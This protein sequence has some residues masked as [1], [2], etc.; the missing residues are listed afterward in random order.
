M[1]KTQG[2]TPEDIPAIRE[3]YDKYFAQDFNFPDFLKGYFC[4]FKITDDSDKLVMAG[5]VRPIAETVLITDKEANVHT[6][7]EALLEALNI[8]RYV[9]E[10]YNID[11][12]HAFVKD[13]NYAKHLV[14]HGFHPRCQALSIK[15]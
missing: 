4:A 6:V 12:L 7:G 10:K 9:C 1:L 2:L 13:Q 3:L 11:Y 5:G 8:S 14:K 15:V